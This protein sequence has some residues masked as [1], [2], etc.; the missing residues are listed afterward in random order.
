MNLVLRDVLGLTGTKFGCG[1]PQ[2]GACTVQ[3]VGQP[4]RSCVLPAVRLVRGQ[5]LVDRITKALRPLELRKS[6]T[7][8]EDML[9]IAIVK[10]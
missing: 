10:P 8:L 3:L 6:L 9:I 7:A 1:I 2:C 5:L 4:V